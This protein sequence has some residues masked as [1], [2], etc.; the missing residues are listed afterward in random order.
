MAGLDPAIHPSAKER[1]FHATRKKCQA[2]GFTSWPTSRTRYGLK[3][4]VH[5]EFHDDIRI[6]IQREHT[7]KHWPR[8]WKLDLIRASNPEWKDLY[9]QLN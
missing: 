7:I 2:V 6:A 5:V 3:L 9:D 4:L 1:R 8:E